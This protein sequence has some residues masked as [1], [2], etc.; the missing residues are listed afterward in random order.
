MRISDEEYAA[1]RVRTGAASSVTSQTVKSTRS[2][3]GNKTVTIDGD[4]FDSQ[5]EARRW[6][7]LCMRQDIGAISRLRHH[8]QLPIVINNIEVCFYEV[9]FD[10]MEDGRWIVEDYKGKKTDMYVLK[11]KLLS[12]VYGIEIREVK[13]A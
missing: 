2:K 5:G 13:K 11:K 9:D 3:Y 6:W 12:V 1:L 4:T 8:F 10:Y 7:F